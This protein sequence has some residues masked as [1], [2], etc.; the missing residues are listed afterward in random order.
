[1]KSLSHE[2][3][4]LYL[5]LIAADWTAVV[6]ITT[7]IIWLIDSSQFLIGQSTYS[8]LMYLKNDHYWKFSTH[9]VV[10][11]TSSGYQ[12][13]QISNPLQAIK[14]IIKRRKVRLDFSP[15][16]K[17]LNWSIPSMH[18]RNIKLAC[19]LIFKIYSKLILPSF[20]FSR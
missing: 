3:F 13:I 17:T 20:F 9:F 12:E 14:E 16:I 4:F 19:I 2:P 15:S 18:N 11:E 6:F 5:K 10:F 7:S 1:M 8:I